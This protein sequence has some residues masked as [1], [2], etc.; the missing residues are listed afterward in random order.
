MPVFH[1]RSNRVKRETQ[2]DRLPVL[3]GSGTTRGKSIH[4]PKRKWGTETSSIAGIE[5]S[6]EVPLRKQLAELPGKP[7]VVDWGCG[8]GRAVSQIAEQVPK[9][10]CYGFSSD[11]Y[12]AWNKAVEKIK[13]QSLFRH[14]KQIFS[15]TLK[16]TL[17]I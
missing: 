2:I 16:T 17:L 4:L 7:V 10:N 13:T 12:F 1:S 3:A 9:A 15:V 6:L 5:K 11:S 8:S 14:Q